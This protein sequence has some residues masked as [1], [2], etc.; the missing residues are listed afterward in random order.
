MLNSRAISKVG[1]SGETQVRSGADAQA[2]HL[3][4]IEMNMIDV[5]VDAA[6]NDW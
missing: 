1:V 3:D 2:N 4:Q 6:S 5:N